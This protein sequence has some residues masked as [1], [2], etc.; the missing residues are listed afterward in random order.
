MSVIRMDA[1]LDQ[2]FMLAIKQQLVASDFTFYR[3]PCQRK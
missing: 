3:Q 1:N 2:Q